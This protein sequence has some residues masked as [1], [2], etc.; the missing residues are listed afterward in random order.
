M[1]SI[2]PCQTS[3][4]AARMFIALA[5]FAAVNPQ[6][7]CGHM[8]AGGRIMALAEELYQQGFISYPRTETDHFD[9]SMDIMV[10]P[11]LHADDSAASL[12]AVVD[13]AHQLRGNMRKQT[14]AAWRSG[15]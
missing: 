4:L 12:T 13:C 10:R 2:H 14:D 5:N 8:A 1:Q 15:V 11:Q 9:E 7:T 3:C 6:P